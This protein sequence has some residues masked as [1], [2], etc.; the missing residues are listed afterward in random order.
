MP[1]PSQRTKKKSSSS[2]KKRVV[3]Q[4]SNSS[5]SKKPLP[6]QKSLTKSQKK[7][8]AEKVKSEEPRTL[9]RETLLHS[10]AKDFL[11]TW[12]NKT[13]A[14]EISGS[15]ELKFRPLGNTK[16]SGILTQRS[17]IELQRYDLK[18][19]DENTFLAAK[20]AVENGLTLPENYGRIIQ[21]EEALMLDA[22]A[23]A[24]ILQAIGL[25][26]PSSE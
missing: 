11:T 6:T 7:E 21:Q 18:T 17:V 14:V 20:A 15:L 8:L 3:P 4:K 12:K 16:Q 23:V 2:N 10:I 24:L 19:L 5:K 25:L 1:T 13:V 22:D 9:I 26:D